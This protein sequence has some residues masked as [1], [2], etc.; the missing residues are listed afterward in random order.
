MNET[1]CGECEFVVFRNKKKEKKE[2]V[3]NQ[4]DDEITD[5]LPEA[6]GIYQVSQ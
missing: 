4:K 3:H 5:G 2:R 1:Y 6:T